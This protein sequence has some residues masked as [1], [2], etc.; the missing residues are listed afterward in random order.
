MFLINIFY[1]IKEKIT[2]KVLDS[3]V[4][5]SSLSDLIE[6]ASQFESQRSRLC[7][8]N[9]CFLIRAETSNLGCGTSLKVP[10][11]IKAPSTSWLRQKKY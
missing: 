4:M 9:I 3:L 7:W 1:Y 11:T 8:E 10:P 2:N 6:F 5:E